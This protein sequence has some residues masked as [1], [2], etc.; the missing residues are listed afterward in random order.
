MLSVHCVMVQ[1]RVVF[2]WHARHKLPTQSAPREGELAACGRTRLVVSTRASC[3]RGRRGASA[4]RVT[5]CVRSRDGGAPRL[6]CSSAASKCF[7]RRRF[8]GWREHA[9]CGELPARRPVS[10]R[11]AR[12]VAIQNRHFRSS[13]VAM[14]P[15]F[16]RFVVQSRVEP[17]RLRQPS[18]Q[19]SLI[20]RGKGRDCSPPRRGRIERNDVSA[21]PSIS[22]ADTARPATGPHQ[23]SV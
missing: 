10:E 13:D 15:P 22:N 17:K 23:G 6:G 5:S 4:W 19:L 3:R 18:C 7:P 16:A 20:A 2:P 12:L 9:L 1:C 21:R 11:A 8:G 14:P